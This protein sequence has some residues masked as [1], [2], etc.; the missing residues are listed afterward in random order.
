VHSQ[1]DAA[2]AADPGRIHG[3]ASRKLTI[4]ATYST[5]PAV[6]PI[7]PG[8]LAQNPAS[9]AGCLRRLCIPDKPRALV[10]LATRRRQIH[11]SEPV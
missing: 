9:R 2:Q 10:A 3:I 7:F 5:V 4:S 6:P 11:I 8:R 1:F